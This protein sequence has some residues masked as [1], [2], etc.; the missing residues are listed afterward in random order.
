MKTTFTVA[1]MT[2]GGCVRGVTNAIR[3]IDDDA[4]VDVNLPG[5]T[6]SV[7]SSAEAELLMQVIE[8]AGFKVS[9]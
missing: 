8:T 6:V 2:C 1:G 4:V 7:N 5:K 3:R 9:R